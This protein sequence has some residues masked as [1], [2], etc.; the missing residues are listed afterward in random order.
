MSRMTVYGMVQWAGERITESLVWFHKAPVIE[1]RNWFLV[2]HCFKVPSMAGFCF[3]LPWSWVLIIACEVKIKL[4]S[5]TAVDGYRRLKNTESSDRT[6]LLWG[7]FFPLQFTPKMNGNCTVSLGKGSIYRGILSS[8]WMQG[9]P[10]KRRAE[11]V[12]LLQRVS[13]QALI[14]Q[15]CEG[16]QK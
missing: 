1:V 6:S 15:C 2:P 10:S 12:I 13:R 8:M 7:F 5:K 3:I 14:I 16:L 11:T 4:I 9:Q